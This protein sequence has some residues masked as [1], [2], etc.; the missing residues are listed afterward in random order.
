MHIEHWEVDVAIGLPPAITVGLPLSTSPFCVL[1]A[2][3][4]SARPTWGGVF[5][6]LAPRTAT[7]LPPIVTD[8]SSPSVRGAAN[9]SGPAGAVPE[10]LGIMCPGHWPWILSPWTSGCAIGRPLVERHRGALDLHLA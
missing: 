10:A 8:D 4:A 1:G 3:K 9:G 5:S 2:V 7:G 6:P